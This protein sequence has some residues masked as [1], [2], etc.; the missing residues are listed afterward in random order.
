[1][2]HPGDVVSMIQTDDRP[3]IGSQE[4]LL[5]GGLLSGFI[6]AIVGVWSLAFALLIGVVVP[7]AFHDPAMIVIGGLFTSEVGI[8]LLIGSL[9]D[10]TLP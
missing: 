4:W 3:E 2:I 5:G 9:L 8:T 7:S 1:M 6:L 10:R